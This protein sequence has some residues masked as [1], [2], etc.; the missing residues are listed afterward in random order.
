[1]RISDFYLSEVV[2][3][4]DYVMKTTETSHRQNIRA[5]GLIKKIKRFMEKTGN[6]ES[7]YD[8]IKEEQNRG[9]L[10]KD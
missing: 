8:K 2:L 1:M 4:C 3:I 9:V 10:F 7:V 6:L 5:K